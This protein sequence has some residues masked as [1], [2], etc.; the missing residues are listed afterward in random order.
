MSRLQGKRVLVVEDDIELAAT[1]DEYLA[2]IG[3]VV[4]GPAFNLVQAELFSAQLDVDVAILDMSLQSDRVDPLARRLRERGVAFVVATG[5]AASI[6]A[7][8][9]GV[10]C[11][12]KPY[13]LAE[14]EEA[15]FSAT[16]APA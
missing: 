6:A 1:L 4:V 13:T 15:L 16:D 14:M 10:V 9:P 2:G 3:A 12:H 7:Q 5:S 11:L 8:P